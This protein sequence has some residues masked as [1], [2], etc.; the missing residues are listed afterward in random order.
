[1][2]LNRLWIC[3]GLAVVVLSV[4]ACGAF[5][6][7][8]T[9]SG[10]VQD[11]FD[12]G[13]SGVTVRASTGQSTTTTADGSY[14]IS[15]A[16]GWSGLV[17]PEGTQLF[18]PTNYSYTNLSSNISGRDY[19]ATPQ[20]FSY[21]SASINDILRGDVVSADFDRDG[22]MDI[23]I[24]GLKYD[25]KSSGYKPVT[26]I[27]R[28]GDGLDYTDIS[29]GLTGVQDSALAWGDYNND[30]K[31]D[32]IVTGDTGSGLVTKLYRNNDTTWPVVA[33]AVFPGV[34]KG[35]VVW[36]DFD[37]DGKLDVMLAGESASG[38]ITKLFHN[39]GDGSFAEVTGLALP[40][41]SECSVAF[42]DYDNDGLADLAIAGDS[43]SG[44]I[45]KIYRNEGLGQF[46]DINAGL[47]AVKSASICWGDYD[48]DGKLDLA[49]SGERADGTKIT[50][51]CRN[52]GSGFAEQDLGLPGI[53]G[54][55]A[56]CDFNFD[57]A[58]DLI[59]FGEQDTSPSLPRI[60]VNN[61]DG[62]FNVYPVAVNEVGYKYASLA[63]MNCNN[64]NKPDLV[65]CGETA[66]GFPGTFIY[67]NLTAASNTAPNTPSG[68][69][70]TFENDTL[71]M[72]W[73]AATDAQTPQA[74]LTYNIR[75]GT[76][77]GA[78]DVVSGQSNYS[79]GRRDSLEMGNAYNNL[80]R[81]I[82]NLA[83]RTYY[84]SVQAIDGSFVGSAWA[85]EATIKPDTQ[86]PSVQISEPSA[87]ITNVG[88]VSYVVTYQGADSITLSVDDITL[89]TT[90][91][92]DGSVSV[93]GSGNT[94]RTV[95][96]ADI[97]GEGSI[98]ISI[99]AG[100]AGNLAGDFSA[101]AG[102][103]ATFAVGNIPPTISIGSPS[104]T[105]TRSGPVT[106]TI[107][108]GACE[109]ITLTS[110]DVT[111][112]KTGSADGTV[113]I[114]GS[115]LSERTVTI[116][117]ITGDG[118]F[119]ISIAMGTAIDAAGNKAPA[120]G[121]SETVT[122]DNTPPVVQIDA[123]SVSMTDGGP[124]AFE[125]TYSGAASISL[126]A[127]DVT[128]NKTGTADGVVSV[129]GEGLTTRT[130]TVSDITG[131]GALG[132]SL[133]A[134]TAKDGIGNETPAAGP[135]NTFAVDN[136][137]PTITIGKPSADITA[138]GPVSFEVTYNDADSISLAD[139]DITLNLTGTATGT[140]SVSGEEGS[141]R[142]VT[143]SDIT[144][145][146]TIGISIAAGTAVD[147]S[148]NSALEAGPSDVFIVDNTPPTAPSLSLDRSITNGPDITAT[149]GGA[150]DANDISYE[151]K[152]NDKP[153]QTAAS[154]WPVIPVKLDDGV[155][156]VY[157][158][159]VD[160]A[161]NIGPEVS[162]EFIYDKTDPQIQS[163]SYDPMLVSASDPMNVT[164][165]VMDN[166]GVA[167]VIADGVYL[168]EG[169]D[170]LW[171]GKVVAAE[172]TGAHTVY[173]MAYDEAGNSGRYDW[174]YNT[175]RAVGLTNKALHDNIIM[176][177]AT[178]FVFT[179]WGRV[180]TSGNTDSFFVDDGS[181]L[182]VKVV[183]P[184]HNFTNGDY[185]SARGT[186]AVDTGSPV[187]TA[188]VVKQH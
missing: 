95:T 41:V 126:T 136:T 162:E 69:S 108:Y 21:F 73:A 39:N 47:T 187:L 29:A 12:V 122:A 58:L 16:E 76:T 75:V 90:G 83:P 33:N 24:A 144:G 143:I 133:A 161:G 159:A 31:A 54:A 36:V 88:P 94:S 114:S 160:A 79:T 177:A 14:S 103:S 86:P 125:I 121:P 186:V 119:G 147:E 157:A 127:E 113:S 167:S 80:S 48:N 42:A 115:G 134:N 52:T 173:V 64:D 9:I 184:N 77:P 65:L 34:K 163:L 89:N 185:V 25:Y 109:T 59:M 50:R 102:P 11:I 6:A 120:A 1:M 3:I 178:R 179:V 100:T 4:S 55:L 7:N 180:T 78:D 44:P 63:W 170:G 181:G 23:A 10:R 128:L 82:H 142:I 153:Y 72:S 110:G 28:C 151:L 8:F 116:F 93:T 85:A 141:V 176:A 150:A 164:V 99:A 84:W 182:L 165:K 117:D 5:A 156:T 17:G 174:T 43:D 169:D 70:A 87:S 183:Y 96:V 53:K 152:V 67:Q 45:T 38:R 91:T 130:V 51:V 131:D 188:Y 175:V 61:G 18:Q 37:N 129:S 149:F 155:H 135:S 97:T 168:T 22:R 123:P 68:L 106:F 62:T 137:P 172:G 98:G 140:V 139:E 74:G 27:W 20:Y 60:C 124:V 13:V 118:T 66:N 158:R 71:T 40:G 19:L 35:T 105:I 57:G 92:A 111:L 32:L 101:G 107:T 56:W 30:G 46:T 104:E 112:N 154:P 145:D 26:Q 166:F 81:Q 148:L 49:F 132:I 146:G 171:T 2:Q 138:G 15:L